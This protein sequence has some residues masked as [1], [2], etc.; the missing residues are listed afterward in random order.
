ML[1]KIIPP[2]VKEVPRRGGAE[3]FCGGS[4]NLNP[5]PSE[6]RYSLFLRENKYP[7]TLTNATPLHKPRRHVIL[8]QVRKND[9]ERA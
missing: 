8:N 7:F 5:S 6:T 4:Q 1:H 2:F 3:D 9:I